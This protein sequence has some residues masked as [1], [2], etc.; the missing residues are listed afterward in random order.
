MHGGTG[1]S[2]QF[3]IG[4]DMKRG[5]VCHELFGDPNFHANQLARMKRY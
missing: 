3:D 5:R 1:M 2:D 4:L